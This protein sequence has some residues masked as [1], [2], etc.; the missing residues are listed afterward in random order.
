SW[1][2][3]HRMEAQGGRSRV[4]LRLRSVVCASVSELESTESESEVAAQRGNQPLRAVVIQSFRLP[5]GAVY[6]VDSWVRSRR[7]CVLRSSHQFGAK[8][9]GG[10]LLRHLPG[11]AG[12]K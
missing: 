1:R 12:K 6:V 10:A 5:G 7:I 2:T 4:S 9:P 8:S 11:A 3:F